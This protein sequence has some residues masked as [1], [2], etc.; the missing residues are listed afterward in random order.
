MRRRVS[1]YAQ[2]GGAEDHR[3]GHEVALGQEPGTISGGGILLRL[4]A[5]GA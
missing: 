4:R 1:V 5:H 2:R 3:G